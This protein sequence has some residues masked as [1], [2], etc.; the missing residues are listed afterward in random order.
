MTKKKQ[1][2]DYQSPVR[3]LFVHNLPHDVSTRK[4]EDLFGKYGDIQDVFKL[5]DGRD[6]AFVSYYNLQSAMNAKAAL[7]DFDWNGD[8]LGV[9]YSI[10]RENDALQLRSTLFV[11]IEMSDAAAAASHKDVKIWFER[12]GPVREVRA[13]RNDAT[14]YNKIRFVEFWD[15][16][17]AERAQAESKQCL[18]NG[19]KIQAR[20]SEKCG[21]VVVTD[22]D[23]K[24]KASTSSTTSN[25]RK[26]RGG[27]DR[28]SSMSFQRDEFRREASA[29][30]YPV[31]S[32]S[33]E[34]DFY[35]MPSTA[36][37]YMP[38]PEVSPLPPP[39][40]LY[41]SMMPFHHLNSNGSATSSSS[42]ATQSS[43]N[44]SNIV[45]YAHPPPPP[46]EYRPPYPQQPL[47]MPTTT[48]YHPYDPYY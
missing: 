4:L 42:S 1:H 33:F 32:P 26:S 37:A 36:A 24:H 28:Q 11:F 41:P 29:P 10:L 17:D 8:R 38:P 7:H 21:S 19:S 15:T 34:K 35:A 43:V 46:Y 20:F 5:Y 12:W 18:F 25:K 31:P 40:M 48:A 6:I 44:S 27:P 14:G 39:A 45:Y 47:M 3:T 13:S 2:T 23:D 30:Y 16:R 9:R 22:V